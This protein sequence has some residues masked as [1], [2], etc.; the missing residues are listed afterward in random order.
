MW[1]VREDEVHDAYGAVVGGEKVAPYRPRR[2]L[3]MT[4]HR[5]TEGHTETR[6][7]VRGDAEEE[8]CLV[9]VEGRGVA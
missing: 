8:G 4:L 2:H 3:T 5:Y 9:T 1:C 7:T 6:H